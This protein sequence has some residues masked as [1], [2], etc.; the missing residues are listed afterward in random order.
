MSS[1]ITAVH[2]EINEAVRAGCLHGLNDDPVHDPAPCRDYA[3]VPAP[4]TLAGEAE[5]S[6]EHVGQLR[7]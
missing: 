1:I 2:G 4:G 5:S 3:T 7:S 6:D